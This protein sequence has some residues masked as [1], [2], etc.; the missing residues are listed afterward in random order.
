MLPRMEP[1]R[2][3]DARFE[4]ESLVGS[5]GMAEVYRAR[6]L[7]S[8]K[9]VA[10][11]VLRASQND[12]PARFRREGVVLARLQ[13]PHIVRYVA[14]G[15]GP[16]GSWLAMEWLEGESLDARLAR[17]PLSVRECVAVGRGAAEALAFAHEQGVLHRDIKPGNLFLPGG[18][19]DEV[20]V[21]DFG[22]A[23]VPGATLTRTGSVVGTPSY[24]SPEQAR[25][26]H[27]DAR[28]DLFSL[29]CVLYEALTGRRAFSGTTPIAVLAKVLLHQPP[30]V[31]SFETAIPGPLSALIA[32]LMEKDPAARPASAS[33]LA[34]SLQRLAG[35]EAAPV[36]GATPALTDQEQKLLTVVLA[37]SAA[38]T[39]ERSKRALDE[40]V[41]RSGARA[42]WL[43]DGSLVVVLSGHR[44]ATDQATLAARSALEIGRE[45]QPAAIAVATGRGTL[46]GPVPVGE[47]I[48]RAASLLRNPEGERGGTVL[49]DEVTLALLDT[50][51]EVQRDRR[52]A[53]LRA[54]RADAE[55]SRLLL[56]RPSPYVGREREL[57]AL[58]GLFAECTSEPAARAV[59]VVGPPGYGKSRLAQEL[60]RR[61]R[62]SPRPPL[63][64]TARGDPMS[65]GSPFGLVSQLV[66][67]AAGIAPEDAPEQRQAKLCERLTPRLPPADA[68]RVV[69]FLGEMSGAG[70]PDDESVELRSGRQDRIL[71]GDQLR[72]AFEEWVAA[73]CAS[74]PQL[75]LLEDLHWGDLP[76]IRMIDAA[77]RAAAE[78]P[79]FVLALAR[80]EAREQWPDLWA[81]RGG[82]EIRL[83]K[84]P[85]RSCERLV[86]EVLGDDF[87]PSESSRLVDSA[88]GNVFHLEELIR[89]AATGAGGRPPASVLAMLTTRLEALEPFARRVLRCAS[90]FGE[91]F[92]RDGLLAVLG[93]ERSAELD[94]RLAELIEHEVLSDRAAAAWSAGRAYA[95]RHSLLREAAY[96]M[97][98]EQDRALGHRLAGSWLEKRGEA[99]PRALAEHFECG[100]ERERAVVWYHRAALAALQGNDLAGAISGVDRAIS[101]GAAGETLNWLRVIAAEAFNWNGDFSRARES[102]FAAYRSCPPGSSNRDDAIAQLA[103]AGVHLSDRALLVDLARE[104][105]EA[106]AAQSEVTRTRALA[107]TAHSLL[108][109]GEVKLGRRLLPRLEAI[110]V[111]EGDR[112]P[113]LAAYLA[114]VRFIFSIVEGNLETSLRC[115]KEAEAAFARAGDQ[116][117]AFDAHGNIGWAATVAGDYALAEQAL[118]EFQLGADRLGLSNSVACAQHNL[119][120]ALAYQGR[121]E[122]SLVTERAALKHFVACG[123]HR[124]AA[125]AHMYLA[126]ALL[127]G[128]DL[129]AAEE[130]ARQAVEGA[131]GSRSLAAS[132]Q[133]TL[134]QVLLSQ[135]R[136]AEALDQAR[137]AASILDE[138]GEIEEREILVRLVLAEALAANAQDEEARRKL[139]EAR[140]RLLA[141]AGKIQNPELRRCFLRNVPEN[142][143]TLQLAGEWLAPPAS[144]PE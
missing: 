89:H 132:A 136:A 63:V 62:N 1:G 88:D 118:S 104:L 46:T 6:E 53:T 58:E 33:A 42:E 82:Q 87:P 138:V 15:Q 126:T 83:G 75:L 123:N 141:I 100:G 129:R 102:A 79:L 137:S 69:E 93:H 29:G 121:L 35:V 20:K 91:L 85:R 18:S 28:S 144:A 143:R 130:E 40:L 4:L 7:V 101:C 5:G 107:R 11:K 72:R 13:H 133:G 139:A 94:L 74:G 59:V 24:L 49:L 120:P 78:Q 70:F 23:R 61:L 44:S 125:A 32:R 41:A 56:G 106:A 54:A 95:F 81:Q 119:G 135:G 50:R 77:L 86:R 43:A 26:G 131:G 90:V 68:R 36:A 110:C 111:A 66:L 12:R 65:A 108:L 19:C 97:L 124:Q 51:F 25:G 3:L 38:F 17:G 16:D 98:T 71:M 128:G 8:G 14:H 96:A 30:P 134:A 127:L 113:L 140:D 99:E 114:N 10:V 31:R 112:H 67:Q 27:L 103:V 45:L 109:I 116:R 76:S 115:V 142:A 2:M 73:E 52:G 21:L 22:I 37:H 117:N 92:W 9:R 84:L 47:V 64:R 57:A 80:P 48:D 105:L 55:P 34:A 39:G 60:L 122:E